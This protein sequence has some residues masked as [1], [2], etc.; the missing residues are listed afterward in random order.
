MCTLT[1]DY[2]KFIGTE[3]QFE[4]SLLMRHEEMFYILQFTY[5]INV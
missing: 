2:N 4:K 1:K 3:N 5:S